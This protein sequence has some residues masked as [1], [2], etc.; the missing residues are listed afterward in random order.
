MAESIK[1]EALGVAKSLW[2][3]YDNYNLPSGTMSVFDA[4][5]QLVK[6]SRALQRLN[7]L[8]CNGVYDWQ[9][10]QYRWNES[11]QL[12]ADKK[13]EKI[14][15]KVSAIIA[16]LFGD[17]IAI[18]FNHDPRGAPIKLYESTVQIGIGN[19]IVCI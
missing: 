2:R 14:D 19:A 13:R 10:R 7:E 5:P 6:A 16:Q 12:K 15:A 1:V 4:A 3:I 9:T 8:E 17:K 18:E 11:D